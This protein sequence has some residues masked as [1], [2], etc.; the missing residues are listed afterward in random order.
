M[1]KN[2]F[3]Y[4][5]S[6]ISSAYYV[7]KLHA[8]NVRVYCRYRTAPNSITIQRC[9]RV[10]HEP[11]WLDRVHLTFICACYVRRQTERRARS[12]LSADIPRTGIFRRLVQCCTILS[13]FCST[14]DL[15]SQSSAASNSWVRIYAM[16]SHH[17]SFL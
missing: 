1:E 9:T 12:H 16:S 14:I 2:V 4:R 7:Y 13:L 5:N 8:K 11:S 17:G 6:V 15:T 3:V 10:M